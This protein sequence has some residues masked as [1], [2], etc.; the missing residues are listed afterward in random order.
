MKI[1]F[2]GKQNKWSHKLNNSGSSLLLVLVAMAFIGILASLILSMSMTNYQIKSVDRQTKEN[3]YSAEIA[4]DEIEIGLQEVV[5]RQL[6][7]AYNEVLQEYAITPVGDRNQR[8]KELFIT[9]LQAYLRVGAT[10]QYDTTKIQ[11]LLTTAS[12][13][14]TI[15]TTGNDLEVSPAYQYLV[16]K[17]L[18]VSY[19]DLSN[20]QTRIQTDIK[21]TAP[22]VEFETIGSK[23]AFCDYALISDNTV[24]V[25]NPV[26]KY[27]VNG[28]IYAAQKILVQ[29]SA[30]QL[31]L[32]SDNIVTR[33]LLEVAN[34]AK[35]V[36]GDD[37]K[38]A[39]IWAR[40][41]E[42]TGL[43][44]G[45]AQATLNGNLYIADDLT[46]NA[47]TSNVTVKGA[48]YGFG[49]G[50][51]ADISSAMLIN[52]S[53]CVLNL[54]ELDRFFLGGRAFVSH[55]NGG[56]S[57]VEVPTGE[58]ISTKVNQNAYLV[59]GD[60]ILKSDGLSFGHNPILASEIGE[61]QDTVN[62]EN[63]VNMNYS[64]YNGKKLSDYADGCKIIYDSEGLA[65]FYLDFTDADV[66]DADYH[67]EKANEYYNAYYEANKENIDANLSYYSTQILKDPVD[68]SRL[69]NAG[70]IVLTN[71]TVS[72]ILNSTVTE[73]L[74]TTFEDEAKSIAEQYK[75]MQEKL[76]LSTTNS[77]AADSTSLYNS[78]INQTP[79]SG[80]VHLIEL[81]EGIGALKHTFESFD[82]NGVKIGEMVLV[83]NDSSTYT[84]SSSPTTPTILIATGDV[85]VDCKNTVAG[86]DF[87]GIIIAKGN[88]SVAAAGETNITA[89][90]DAVY[91]ILSHLREGTSVFLDY[92]NFGF[93]TLTDT[94]MTAAGD[95]DIASLISYENWKKK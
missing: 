43:L 44:S 14:T 5:S 92:G 39:N 45:G 35:L 67:E 30:V 47:N 91:D 95:I 52:R 9:K 75:A 12:A 65:Y 77:V 26:T 34:G 18:G 71:G 66:T 40:D 36:A 82:E 7:A 31:T 62:R 11:A 16:I 25:T 78:L 8:L 90:S 50:A 15:A 57:T 84:V 23:P 19:T 46:L 2:H 22:D 80:I 29:S 27:T 83:N 94:G 81:Y 28:S 85:V 1:N 73:F 93:S 86:P 32:N 53:N 48:Y 13:K 56:G 37:T 70:N 6:E 87:N 59:P 54:N 72:K 55:D 88:I 79:T 49:Y 38:P 17:N 60:S 10:N 76:M 42:T 58:S 74:P 69:T 41:I 63:S 68:F 20:Y 89:A 64:S 24:D 4:L 61:L 3:F 51:T 21:I 33:N